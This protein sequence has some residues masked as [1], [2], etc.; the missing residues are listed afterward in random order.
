MQARLLAGAQES[1]QQGMRMAAQLRIDIPAQWGALQQ[2]ILA[3]AG[4]QRRLLQE[5]RGALEPA[6]V[7]TKQGLL[8]GQDDGNAA[9]TET[10][11]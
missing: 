1:V 4:L 3:E 6:L 2:D 7:R 10:A 8:G 11:R 9:R 5:S